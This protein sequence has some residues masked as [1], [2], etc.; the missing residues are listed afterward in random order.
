MDQTQWPEVKR[1]DRD[2][3]RK[4]CSEQINALRA[5]CA[6]I[7]KELGIAASTLA[8]RAA[9]EAIV[10]SRPRT[11][12]E[13]MENGRLLRWQAERWPGAVEKSTGSSR[14][15]RLRSAGAIRLC[16]SL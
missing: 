2:A 12:D 7:A 15:K 5:E 11:L 14:S 10:R 4:D 6:R 16:V 8:P 3:A 9:I 13:I 1:R